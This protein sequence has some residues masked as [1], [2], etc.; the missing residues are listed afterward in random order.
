MQ[1]SLAYA[2]PLAALVL[3]VAAVMTRDRW[4]PLLT[5]KKPSSEHDHGANGKDD[6]DHAG[7]T[8]GPADKIKLTDA[9][10]ANLGIKAKVVKTS[11][12]WRT[13]MIPGTVI[14]S[15]ALSDRGVT[16][17]AMTVVTDIRV[18][19]GDSVKPGDV[20]F[21][22]RLVSE[23]VQTSQSELFKNSRE[24]QIVKEQLERL[25]SSQGAVA[26]QVIIDKE[27]QLRRLQAVAEALRQE[28][29]T[30][31]L[32]REQ[33]D[34]VDAGEFVREISVVAPPPIKGQ[35]PIPSNGGSAPPFTYEMQ[36][37]KVN[38]GDQVQA[39]Q[40]LAVLSNHSSLLV[41]G[42][43]FRADGGLVERAAREAYPVSVEFV[44]DSPGDWAAEPPVLT[45]SHLANTVDPT[46]RTTSFFLPLANQGRTFQRGGKSVM[47]WRY[48]PGQRVKL[49]VPVEKMADVIVLPPE[50]VTF[51]G[52]EAFVFRQNGD[53]FQRV[54]VHVRYADATAVVVA[55]DG[56]IGP[57]MFVAQSGAAALNRAVKAAQTGAAGGGHHGHDHAH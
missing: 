16:A 53:V 4:L 42:H 2:V 1:R 20:M 27:Q 57:G 9:A 46:T 24:M 12:F 38:L 44:Q 32:T 14:D 10:R 8:H 5:P 37:L 40:T 34:K 25:K 39:G 6:H 51:D 31:G 26:G 22:L 35:L 7:H 21:A 29:A 13:V 55:N 23:I 56:Q 30:R 19:P 17:P 36:E 18:R 45:I 52:P 43:A 33:I 54:G 49:R 50:A 3:I 48:R 41:E 47:I 11:D 28:L 15:P